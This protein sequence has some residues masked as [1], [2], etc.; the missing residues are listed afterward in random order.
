VA[1]SVP[2]VLL[3]GTGY[4]AGEALR[5][6][7]GHPV[8][9]VSAVVSSSQAGQAVVGTFP[10]LGGPGLP[11]HFVGLN[12]AQSAVAGSN[13]LALVSAL[14]HGESAPAI[15]AWLDRLPQT[16]VV[17]ASADLRHSDPELYASVYGRPHPSP[18][19]QSQ[20]TCA[21]PD[22]DPHPATPHV[23]HPGCFTTAVSLACRAMIGAGLSEGPFT[24]FAVTGSTGSGRTP[25][26]TTHHPDRHG[27]FRAYQPL[28]HRHEPEMRALV[29][30]A[31][32]FLPHS[33]SFARGIHATVIGPALGGGPLDALAK[34]AEGKPFLRVV[35]VPPSVK[36]VAG[37][38]RCHLWATERDGQL[39]VVSVIDNLAK[40][41]A[42]GCVHWLNRLFG[43]DET[44]GL[45]G[46]GLGWN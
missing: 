46:G 11:V 33:G 8:F 35:E 3:G 43:L 19:L 9:E 22:L 42:S 24:A 17:D 1:E 30:R 12:D 44:A 4:V 18:S 14:P 25:S 36:D 27:G 2:V 20:F 38:N 37:T 40:G 29:G 39:V 32:S 16:T 23:A 45:H 6:L 31:V 15:A 13:R 41:A 5:W 10:H 28:T 21:L 26:P 7:Q 34:F